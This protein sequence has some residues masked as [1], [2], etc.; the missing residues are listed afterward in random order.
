MCVVLYSVF[1][2]AVLSYIHIRSSYFMHMN[3]QDSNQGYKQN[4]DCSYVQ[5]R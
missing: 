5:L 4:I 2:Y 1:S 3:K